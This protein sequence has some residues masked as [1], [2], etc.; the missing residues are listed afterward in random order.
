MNTFFSK[1]KVI[2]LGC[3]VFPVLWMGGVEILAAVGFFFG[4]PVSRWDVIL[5]LIPALVFP[6]AMARKTGT[7]KLQIAVL[8]GIAVMLAVSYGLAGHFLDLT[9]DGQGYHQSAIIELSRGWN[10]VSSYVKTDGNRLLK[11]ANFYSKGPWI[12]AASVFRLS[13]NI[14]TGK[15]FNLLLMMSAFLLSLV[16]LLRLKGTGR[17]AVAL[18]I[19]AALNPVSIC[20]MFGFLVDGQ[21]ASLLVIGISLGVLFFMEESVVIYT[22]FF[23]VIV[24]GVNVKF[25]GVAYMG[26]IVFFLFG[27]A[28]LFHRSRFTLRRVRLVVY[29]GIVAFLI[30]GFNPYVT[31]TV[32]Y[33]NPFHPILGAHRIDL[34][35]LQRPTDFVG[36]NR[37]FK[38]YRS[39]FSRSDN[40]Q[41]MYLQSSKPKNPFTWSRT[42]FRW[43]VQS[44]LRVGGFGP[45]FG[46]IIIITL[47]TFLGTILLYR[48]NQPEW[49]LFLAGI[50][51]SVAINPDSWWARLAPQL[52]LFPLGVSLWFL[53]LKKP[54]AKG[55]AGVIV[56]LL[57][58]NVSGILWS[59]G[60]QYANVNRTLKKQLIALQ[61]HPVVLYP[62]LLKSVRNRLAYYHI[63]FREVK[64]RQK[65][66]CKH[67]EW[68]TWSSAWY[69]PDRCFSKSSGPPGRVRGFY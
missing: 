1:Q 39:I 28:W 69:C 40:P 8:F 63:P 26:L 57:S 50:L 41:F 19:L 60:T 22:A 61:G 20:Q 59:Y 11:Y 12:C 53:S 54:L 5:S 45:L 65:L 67:P 38:L 15:L 56:L 47:L 21:L 10:P 27:G 66:P 14:E 42:E 18:A 52:W 34:L 36:K 68:L 58:L 6:L 23:A 29:G 4:I 35:K 51:I 43:F 44:S 46:G 55:F 17:F 13:G 7:W 9:W 3:G 16:L 33:G 2:L 37:F 48:I 30:V 31:N 32:C 62:G 64:R 25:N 24:L 49:M